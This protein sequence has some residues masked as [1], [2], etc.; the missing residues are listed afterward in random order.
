MQSE[1]SLI[2]RDGVDY[3]VR[4]LGLLLAALNGGFG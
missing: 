4:A 3:S 2:A 1:I